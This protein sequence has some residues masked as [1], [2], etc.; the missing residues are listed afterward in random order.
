[1]IKNHWLCSN[2]NKP[3]D[4]FGT[5]N[6]ILS[7]EEPIFINK[8]KTVAIGRCVTYKSK[9]LISDMLISGHDGVASNKPFYLHSYNMVWNKKTEQFEIKII[10]NED[11]SIW[12]IYYSGGDNFEFQIV[13]TPT[14]SESKKKPIAVDNTYVCVHHATKI[15]FNV[16]IPRYKKLYSKIPEKVKDINL[17]DIVFE[18]KY[19]ERKTVFSL[20]QEFVPVLDKDII[21]IYDI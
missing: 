13:E 19:R 18:G 11:T 16:N 20:N 12:F 1:M 6:M 5:G 2:P 3:N 17:D 9:K 8:K 15:N 14:I 10:D 7:I 21:G 4:G